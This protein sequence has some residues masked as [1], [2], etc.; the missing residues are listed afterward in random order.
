M[1]LYL[2]LLAPLLLSFPVAAAL[3]PPPQTL[4]QLEKAL[5]RAD[6]KTVS[7]PMVAKTRAVVEK[8]NGSDREEY[9]VESVGKGDGTEETKLLFAT[10]DG[11][12]VTAEKR[13][14]SEKEKAEREKHPKPQKPPADARKEKNSLGM[15]IPTGDDRKLFVLG[16]AKSEGDLLVVTYE[17]ARGAKGEELSRGRIAWNAA[18]GEPAYIDAQLVNPP[19][20]LKELHVRGEFRGAGDAIYTGVLRTSGVGG[21]LWIKRK[22]EI[23]FEMAP[24]P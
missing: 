5:E 24:A 13:A 19:T 22:F 6:P 17:P 1:K 20:G 15:K 12:D 2:P 14:E 16:E 18:T 9:V 8:P 4:V 3:E 23:S 10:K 21:L 11:K 7:R